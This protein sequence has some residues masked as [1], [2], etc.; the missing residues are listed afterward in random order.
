M[1][2]VRAGRPARL[3]GGLIVLFQRGIAVKVLEGIAAG[4]HTERL[5]ILDL[6]LA[7]SEDRRRDIVHKTENSLEAALRRGR[8]G[9]R[10]PRTRSLIWV[11]GHLLE[12][13]LRN[14]RFGVTA[15]RGSP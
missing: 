4:E 1:L 11:C 12:D 5:L 2:T 9:D 15:R 8:G 13:R 6:S 3:L 10:G 7:L 14:V